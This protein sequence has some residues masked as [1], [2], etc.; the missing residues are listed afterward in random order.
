MA[1]P[2]PP[3]GGSPPEPRKE[4]TVTR[5]PNAG[6]VQGHKVFQG[7]VLS[8][9]NTDGSRKVMR[10][11][12]SKGAFHRRRLIV[13]W[14]LI[15]LFVALPF[16][17]IGGKPAILLD[18]AARR[19]TFFGATL[20]PSD[21]FVLLL[22]MLT[23]FLSIF[24]LTALLGRVWC[25][26]ACP[27]TVYMEFLFRPIERWIEGGRTNSIRM[28]RNGWSWRRWA[29]F[30]IFAA[31]SVGLAN[32]FLAYFVG[33]ETLGQWMTQSPFENPGPFGVVAVTT[34]LVFVD[35]GVFRE[36]MCTVACPYARLQSVLL[37]RKSLIIG[38]DEARGEPRG[39]QAKKADP[40]GSALGSVPGSALGDCIDCRACV[41]TCPTG[42]DIREGLQLECI[43]CAQCV[44]AC[45]AIMDKIGRP[46]G[47]VR[48]TSQ[49][50]LAGK[51]H[52]IIRP[53][54]LI[55]PALIGIA[56]VGLVLVIP[57][58]DQ[59][60]STLLRGIGAPFTVDASGLVTNT[61]RIKVANRDEVAHDYTIELV[62]MEGAVLIA[63][64]NPF[65][66]GPEATELQGV[67]IQLPA[68]SVPADGQRNFKIRLSDGMGYV[69]EL[70]YTF[71]GPGASAAGA[72]AAGEV[73][74]D[75]EPGSEPGSAS[76]PGAEG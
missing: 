25:G 70:P 18:L 41:T 42:I 15:V 17:Q 4:P 19:F 57:N 7:Q 53:R 74:T 45:D 28:D 58:A 49:D 32:V 61:V 11:Q 63:P 34:A 36:Q 21:T 46:R 71:L 24:F 30:S 27:Q 60:H 59:A 62:D 6:S 40:P 39:K 10:P 76:A 13:G 23:I 43:G 31:I 55:Y 50:G 8:T 3:D 14:S 5:H 66:V 12:L 69:E 35:F 56:L 75:L 64:M 54:V 65:T 73:E 29:K 2:V 52:R 48:Y 20:L 9:L 51:P 37:D 1:S 16:I 47:L 44:D 26:W 33:V 68:S 67:F 38:Y 22:F 72:G